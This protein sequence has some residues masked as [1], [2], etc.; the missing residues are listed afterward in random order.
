MAPNPPPKV[1]DK[2]ITWTE[3]HPINADEMVTASGDGTV[4]IWRNPS[5]T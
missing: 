4:K 5:D 2:V 1:H 3:H